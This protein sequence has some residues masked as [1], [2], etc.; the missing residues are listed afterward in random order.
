MIVAWLPPSYKQAQLTQFAS[1]NWV[2]V[3][4]HHMGVSGV[5]GIHI[6]HQR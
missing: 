5:S 4:G 1:E 2:D 6:R 3:T